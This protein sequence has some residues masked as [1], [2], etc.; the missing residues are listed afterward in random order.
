MIDMSFLIIGILFFLR[1]LS[2]LIIIRVLLS[3]FVPQ[4][5]NRLILFIYDTSD[6]VLMPIRHIF[7]LRGRIDW[8]PLIAIILIDLIQYGIVRIFS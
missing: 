2:W 8:T 4:A 7:R 5:N 1:V 3:W 6:A